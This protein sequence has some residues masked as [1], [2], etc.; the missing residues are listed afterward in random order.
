MRSVLSAP[1]T[2]A[3]EAMGAIKVYSTLV[4]AYGEREQDVLRRFAAQAAIFVSNVKTVQA[5][6][7]LSDALQ[8]T[9]RT[10]DLLAMARGA[11]MARRGLG[12]EDA[13]RYLMA[14]SQRTRQGIR[15]LAERIVAFPREA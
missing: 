6:E 14:E 11:V 15:E 4:D 1:L 2:G 12:A 3:A 5:A 10:R 8:E 13:T 7:H 9:L